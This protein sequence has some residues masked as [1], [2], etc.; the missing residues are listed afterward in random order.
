MKIK[1]ELIEEIT[2]EVLAVL[3]EMY[4]HQ[5]FKEIE[6][7]IGLKNTSESKFSRLINHTDEVWHSFN[8]EDFDRAHKYIEDNN[9][10]GNRNYYREIKNTPDSLY[11]SLLAFYNVR[12]GSER[13]TD[14][15]SVV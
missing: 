7:V 10:W 6:K 5:S 11:H 8:R 4:L 3:R 13:D 9:L 1:R 2:K 14:R 12:Y 15:K